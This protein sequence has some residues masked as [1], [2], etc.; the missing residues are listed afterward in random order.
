MGLL[1]DKRIK[2]ITDSNK[3]RVYFLLIAFLLAF[4]VRIIGIRSQPAIFHPTK[5]YYSALLSRSYYL[6]TEKHRYEQERIPSLMFR[7]SKDKLEPGINELLTYLMYVMAGKEDLLIPR[8]MSVLYW[9]TGGVF[10]Y[11]I[12]FLFFGGT[13][14]VFSLIFYLFFPFGINISQSIQSESLLNMFFLWAV[15]QIVKYFRSDNRKYFY[16]AALLSGFAVLLKLTMI[17]P[18]AGIVLFAGINKYGLK[19]FLFKWRTVW[20]FLLFFTVGL[21]FYFYNIL[22]NTAMRGAAS[23]VIFPGLLK[24]SYFW[25]G[26]LIQTGKVTGVVP[27]LLG[28]LLLLTIKNKETQ[29]ML[30]GLLAGY[31]TFGL[32]FSYTT[33]THDYYQLALF[34]ITALMLGQAG[35]LLKHPGKM[36]KRNPGLTLS[37]SYAVLCAAVVF[38]LFHQFSFVQSDHKLKMWSP[39]FFLVGEQG[40]FFANNIPEKN[41]IENAKKI[42]EITGHSIN[43]IFLS[44]SYGH[45]VMYYGAM[46]GKTWPT[47]EDL[48]FRRLRGLENLSAD[49]LYF[50]KFENIKPG[51]FIITDLDSWK[52][53]PD[54]QKFLRETFEIFSKKKE[55]II[56]NLRKKKSGNG[57]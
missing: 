17:F 47:E 49:R 36:E 55:Y 27:L 26:W 10:I 50:S 33:A 48:N 35:Y 6:N 46:F 43:N 1:N 52:K 29:S 32:A 56:F 40:S 34:P 44:R 18:L 53:Q 51:F 15:L 41:I 14:A 20:F 2:I 8:L 16:S 24:L 42:G 3:Q 57:E 23:S 7:N 9:L 30:S 13:G 31:F 12:A 19:E 28:V 21:S 45:T 11:K 39:A 54:L 22:W 38:S 25:K 37:A 5:Q 4:S